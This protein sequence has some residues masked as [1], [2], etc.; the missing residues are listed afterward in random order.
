MTKHVKQM[1]NMAFLWIAS[2]VLAAISIAYTHELVI[3]PIWVVNV[4]M[5]YYLIQN[6]KIVNSAVFNFIFSFSAVF[7]ASYLF[8]QTK[9]IEFKAILSLIGSIQVLSFIYVY[10]WI[11]ERAVQYE[12]FHTL[13]IT[14]P[15]VI[16][17]LI[18]AALFTMCFD[19][20]LNYYEFLD[21][22]LE[23]FATGVS[24]MCILYGVSH[25]RNIPLTDYGL[26]LL[27]WLAQYF[28]SVDPIFYACF[29][30]PFLMCYF[31]LKYKLREFSFLIGVLSFVCSVY[32]SMPI[33]GEYWDATETNMLSRLSSYRLALG[34]YLVI[35]LFICEIYLNNKR[36]S[37]SYERMMFRDE[38]TTLKNRRYVREKVLSDRNFK[39][40]YLLLL[41]IDNFKKVNDIY[42]HYVGDL[43]INHITDILRQLKLHDS[44]IARWGGEEF[45]LMVPNASEKQCR[46]TCDAILEACLDKPFMY[47]DC[48][49]EVTVSIGA[50]TFDQFNWNHYLH[51]LHE[52]DQSL[53]KAK[54]N[55]KK[56]YVLKA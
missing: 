25:W 50:T 49:I 8:D 43:V 56:Q 19:F 30:F 6:R 11:A 14:F 44:V 42:G 18:G 45:L 52:A 20:G 4:V 36:L 35:F 7:L 9:P 23:Q 21:Y 1:K 17:S 15:N 34:C 13:A 40:G 3:S 53:Y 5:S 28:I 46:Q 32:V 37:A 54:A 24:I 26:V 51:W 31:A 47:K 55:G 48:Q 12:Y 29:I 38:L 22:F 41:D 33:A 39:N 10:Y 27:A 2:F 16:S